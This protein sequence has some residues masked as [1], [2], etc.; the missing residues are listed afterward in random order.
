MMPAEIDFIT[1]AYEGPKFIR[2]VRHASRAMRIQIL[3]VL[4]LLSYVAPLR[5]EPTGSIAAPATKPNL[6]VFISDDHGYSDSSLGGAAGFP[7]PN[8]RR[9]ARLGMTFTHAFAASPSCAPSR[10]ALLTGLMPTRNGAMLNHQPPRSNVKKLPAYLQ[11]LGYEVVAFGKVAHYKQGQDYGFDHVAHDGFHDDKC[12]TAAVEFLKQ[13]GG[14]SPVCLLVGTNWPHVP[15]PEAASARE[16]ESIAPPSSHVDTPETRHWRARY[17]AAVER[18]DEDLGQ[19]FDAAFEELGPNTL[20]I[21]FSDHGAQWPFGKWNLYD[22]GTRV[23]F[24]AVWPGVV[25][26]RSESA[27]LISLVDVLPT[28]IDAAAGQPP[29]DIDGRSFLQVL[30]GKRL[31]FREAIYTTHSGDGAMNRY[32]MRSVRT[33]DWKYIRNLR[34]EAE[35][36]TH[37]DLGKAVDGKEY[38]K[39]WIERARTDAR[40]AAIVE[41]YRRRPAEE[42]YDLRNDPLEQHNVATDPAQ[43]RR[44]SQLRAQLASWMAQQGDRGR[45]TED[46]AV[47]AFEASSR[48]AAASK[49]AARQ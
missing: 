8:L 39:A 5:G 40:A 37:I 31:E 46:S 2:A 14:P 42:L 25:P 28:L 16:G 18:F 38:W 19:L 6:V 49:A 24:V 36:T 10:A 13:R 33:R 30:R 20:F 12:V 1:V 43:H 45:A 22:A 34:P 32:P 17:A 35:H 11:E 47:E 15:W 4:G 41:R 48:G 7:T 44:L 29:S 27:A 26:P 9:I 21:H 23:P 3:I